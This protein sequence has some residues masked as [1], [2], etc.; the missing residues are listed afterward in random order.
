M[1]SLFPGAAGNTEQQEELWS[2]KALTWTGAS[3]SHVPGGPPSLGDGE[4]DL[5][6]PLPVWQESPGRVGKV[7][8]LKTCGL[9]GRKAAL[10]GQRTW[11]DRTRAAFLGK[12]G[13][14]RPGRRW[15]TAARG[16]LPLGGSHSAWP[17][18]GSWRGKLVLRSDHPQL[19]SWT[20][21]KIR[22]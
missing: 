9:I 4:A 6:F 13:L 10:A 12:A 17:G 1:R 3:D 5:V 11:L 18:L 16:E 19:A 8:S 2:R 21:K 14:R 20:N 7:G 15:R 22:P